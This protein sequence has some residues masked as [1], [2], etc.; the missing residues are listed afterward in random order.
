M[1][2]PVHITMKGK[3][4]GP[5]KGSCTQKGREDTMLVH[6]FTSE[7]S[8]PTDVFT[9]QASGKRVHKPLTITK[10]VDK[11]SPQLYLAATTGEI[12]TEVGLKFYRI[13]QLGKEENYFTIMLTNATIIDIK[14][15]FPH[16]QD[17][18]TAHY[19]HLEDVSLTYQKIQWRHEID[20]TEAEDDWSVPNA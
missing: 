16:T 6:S 1:P 4:Q 14:A 19:G 2:M 10:E 11:A 18:A 13:N 17:K 15:W 5:I 20:K 12:L 9:G 8:I 7:V 3:K